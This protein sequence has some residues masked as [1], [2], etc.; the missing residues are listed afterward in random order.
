MKEFIIKDFWRKL[1]N[2]WT[3]LFL[4]LII[5][6]FVTAGSYQ[7]LIPAF[8]VIYGAILSIFVGTKEFQRWYNLYH[9]K[10]HPGEVFVFLWTVLI[11]FI[12]IYSWIFKNKYVI[13]SDIISVYVM[14]LTVFAISQGSKKAYNK[15]SKYEK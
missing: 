13:S 8:S 3:I 7:Y 4:G 1:A 5:S 2:I 10:K 11:L 6:D 9:S 14:V 12:F 15:K